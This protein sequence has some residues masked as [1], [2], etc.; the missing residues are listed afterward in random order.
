MER[1]IVGLRMSFNETEN[2]PIAEFVRIHQLSPDY[3][4]LTE[5]QKSL[6]K[7]ELKEAHRELTKKFGKNAEPTGDLPGDQHPG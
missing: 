2:L 5:E 4:R 7:K 6:F 1:I 3:Q